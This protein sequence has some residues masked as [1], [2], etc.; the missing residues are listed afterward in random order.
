MSW[1]NKETPSEKK[2]TPSAHGKEQSKIPTQINILTGKITEQAFVLPEQ[3]NAWAQNL[4]RT[5]RFLGIY[6]GSPPWNSTE[7]F[8]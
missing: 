2:K 6:I 4:E 5:E 3:D 7:I 8:C 1:L